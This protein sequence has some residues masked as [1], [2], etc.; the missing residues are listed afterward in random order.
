MHTAKPIDIQK[1]QCEVNRAEGYMMLAYAVNHM[2]EFVVWERHRDKYQA[3]IDKYH[4]EAGLA[5]AKKEDA[6]EDGA[7]E[8]E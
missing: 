3:M 8:R 1:L 5:R 2:D 6:S 4:F 7:F